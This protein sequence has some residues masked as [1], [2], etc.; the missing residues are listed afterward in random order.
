MGRSEGSA[1]GAPGPARGAPEGSAPREVRVLDDLDALSDAAA[2]LTAEWLTAAQAARGSAS[3]ALSGGSTPQPTYERLAG[4]AGR[5]VAWKNI[6][7]WFGDERCVPPDDPR[8]NYGMARASLLDHI[9]LDPSRVH[10]MR[11]ELPAARAA[12]DYERDLRA[13]FAAAASDPALPLL[14][15]AHLGVGDDGHT[16]SL[17]PGAPVLE[18]RDRWAARSTAP[19]TSPVKDRVT[20]TF[21]ALA[22]SRIVCFICA[23]EGKAEVLRRILVDGEE[24]PAGRVYGRERTVWLL[25][26]GAA[27]RL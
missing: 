27:R 12:D 10:R 22:R 11:G 4:E 17:F 13:A 15:V 6:D 25:D 1:A 19:P 18:E 23:G 16:A 3:L 7:I 2:A 14:D 5:G 9:E 24:L 26:R 20:L 8:S 21:P